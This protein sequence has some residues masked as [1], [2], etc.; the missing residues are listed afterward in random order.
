MRRRPLFPIPSLLSGLGWS[1]GFSRF[2]TLRPANAGTPTRTRRA[3]R[4]LLWAGAIFAALQVALAALVERPCPALRDPEYGLKLARLRAARA[5]EP[6]RPLVLILGSSRAECGVRPDALRPLSAD[7]EAGPLVF[8]FA[9]CGA[10]PL[11][12]LLVLNRLLHEGIRPDAVV[13]ELLPAFLCQDGVWAEE[14]RLPLNRVYAADLAVLRRNWTRPRRTCAAW[15]AD[16]ALSWHTHRFAVLSRFRPD[17]LAW[18]NRVDHWNRLDA[19]GWLADPRPSVSAEQYAWAFERARQEY[20]ACLREF[21]VT[22]NGDGPLRELLATCRRHGIGLVLLTMPE[23]RAFRGLYPPGARTA[24]DDY[25]NGLGR[26][27]GACWI[28]ARDWLPDEAF[29]DGHHLLA[30]S[31]TEFSSRLGPILFG[32][33]PLATGG[34]SP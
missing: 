11:I 28:D 21:R 13:V 3:R 27:Y 2:G 34:P 15:L 24:I 14:R 12:E 9:V 30:A 26:T 8:N 17:L 6:R 1:P 18:S 23:S 20:G 31:A 22:P 16:S 10:G 7:G 32:S 4:A 33:R 25:L 5:A 29:V 19:L